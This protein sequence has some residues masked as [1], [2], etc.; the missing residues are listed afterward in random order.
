MSQYLGGT[1]ICFK[2]SRQSLLDIGFDFTSIDQV[3]VDDALEALFS[4]NDY[5]I[6]QKAKGPISI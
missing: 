5:F 1:Q 3:E 2:A 6:S 4:A